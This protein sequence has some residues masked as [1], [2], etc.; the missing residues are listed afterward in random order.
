[1]RPSPQS[2]PLA[3]PLGSARRFDEPPAG[4]RTPRRWDQVSTRDRVLLS[5]L[6]HP[7]R[8]SPRGR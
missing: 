8:P 2:T 3:Q 4:M 7:D 1:M 6:L 5:L